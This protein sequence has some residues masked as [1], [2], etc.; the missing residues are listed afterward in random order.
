MPAP[1]RSGWP[2]VVRVC[3]PKDAPRYVHLLRG[4]SPRSQALCGRHCAWAPVPEGEALPVCRHCERMAAR[5]VEG[6]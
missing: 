2:R 6:K 5:R 4:I 1:L 3:R